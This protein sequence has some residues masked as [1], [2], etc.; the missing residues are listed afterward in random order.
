M[1][2]DHYTYPMTDERERKLERLEDMT[3]TNTK[4]DALDLAIAH[5]F[6]S[7][8]NFQEHWEEFT[9]QE[10]RKLGTDA[11]SPAYYPKF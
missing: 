4:A 7:R 1:G 2:K 5:Y 9:P 8:A 3:G 10:L 11:V 6:E